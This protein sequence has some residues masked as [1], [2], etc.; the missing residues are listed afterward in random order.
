MI[1][2]NKIIP[3]QSIIQ[4][5]LRHDRTPN[6]GTDILWK[7][8]RVTW[9]DIFIC[10][11]NVN[12]IL[13]ESTL[14]SNCRNINVEPLTGVWIIWWNKY[15][16]L[17]TPSNYSNDFN[18]SNSRGLILQVAQIKISSLMFSP[19]NGDWYDENKPQQLRA[20]CS[21]TSTKTFFQSLG[22]TRGL[23]QKAVHHLL[24]LLKPH[25]SNFGVPILCWPKLVAAHWKIYI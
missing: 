22:Q 17:F 14:T 25:L 5:V 1:W 24:K 12:S 8:V 10:V 3:C 19:S 16:R 23:Y 7:R 13:R 20:S 15:A 11:F 4:M 9:I 2:T 6:Q 21:T 18:R